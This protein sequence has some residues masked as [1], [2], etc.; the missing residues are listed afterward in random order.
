[1]PQCHLASSSTL[2]LTHLTAMPQH[3]CI[4]SNRQKSWDLPAV[5]VAI[6]LNNRFAA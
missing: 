2:H 1:M 6:P 5:L 3:C 4:A